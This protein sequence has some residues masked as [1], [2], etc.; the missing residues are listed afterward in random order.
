YGLDERP[1]DR[2]LL[3]ADPGRPCRSSGGLRQPR[4]LPVLGRGWLDQRPTPVQQ[5][6]VA[7]STSNNRISLDGSHRSP[8]PLNVRVGPTKAEDSGNGCL[9]QPASYEVE[10]PRVVPTPVF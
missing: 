10:S 1:A 4:A 5:R 9:P 7:V 8:R 3:P 2:E 6:R